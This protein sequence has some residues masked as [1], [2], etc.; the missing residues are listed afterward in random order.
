[1]LFHLKE[2]DAQMLKIKLIKSVYKISV[3][4][5]VRRTH[6]SKDKSRFYLKGREEISLQHPVFL[7]P[8]VD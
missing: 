7:V 1:M 8:H 2:I 4:A 5:D 6:L 3:D